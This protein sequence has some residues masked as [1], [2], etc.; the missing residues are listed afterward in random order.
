MKEDR[1]AFKII[2]G[3]PIGKRPLG[4]VIRMGLKEIG[5]NTRNWFDLSQGMVYWRT[6][7]NV[8]LNLWVL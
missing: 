4:G 7:M 2:I 3:N 1:S 5:I 8:E 6:L